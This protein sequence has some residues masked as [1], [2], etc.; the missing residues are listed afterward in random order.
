MRLSV[1]SAVDAAT[2]TACDD[3]ARETGLEPAWVKHHVARQSRRKTVQEALDWVRTHVE[4]VRRLGEERDALTPLARQ[5]RDLG[6]L[7]RSVAL[8]KVNNAD[9]WRFLE[10]M[11]DSDLRSSLVLAVE[12]DRVTEGRL[13][14]LRRLRQEAVTAPPVGTRVRGRM[15]VLRHHRERDLRVDCATSEGWIARLTVRDE[16]LSMRIQ[17]GTVSTLDVDGTVVWCGGRMAV[18]NG[19]PRAA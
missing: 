10:G 8:W 3:L 13:E 14:L 12:E 6:H 11:A 2:H 15:T 7:A 9:L 5:A 18:V 19:S 17:L 1:A 4:R 16:A